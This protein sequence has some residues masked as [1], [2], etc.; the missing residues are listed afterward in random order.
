M[1]VYIV[2]EDLV[3]YAIIK[4]VL[5]Y[6]SNDFKIISELP[7]RGGQVRSKMD[8]FNNLSLANPVILLTD[9]DAETCAPQLVRQLIKKD[10]NDH[11]ILNIAV[12]EAE[13]WLMAD[14]EGFAEYFKIKIEDMPPAHQTKQG[15]RK[16]LTE[17]KFDYKPSLFLTHELVK[18]IKHAELKQQLTPK[19][20][21]TKGPEYNSCLLP[22]IQYKWD[23]T[24]ARRNANS[25]DRMIGRMR[26]LIQNT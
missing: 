18:K 23:I 22:F 17:M 14:R 26:N 20:G 9:L 11:F 6:C 10:K 2:G 13:A 15:G 1:N 5:A 21:A 24:N 19:K 4:R 8:E 7:A 25:L 16:A 3:T 12:D